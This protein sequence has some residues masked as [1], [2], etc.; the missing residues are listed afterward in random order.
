M[1][2]R[3]LLV[4]IGEKIERLRAGTSYAAV[5]RAAGCS[6]GN[7]RQLEAGKIASPRVELCLR[8]ARHFGVP[9][10][11]LADEAQDWPPPA[12]DDE[13]AAELVRGALVGAGLAGE[14][15]RDERELLSR[16]RSLS[17]RHRDRVLGL[18]IGLASSGG[19]EEAAEL[20][21]DVGEALGEADRQSGE[22]PRP[23]RAEGAAC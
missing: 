14:L 5:A 9:L 3:K 1:G 20:A 16:Y 7:L 18:V 4:R 8:I 22:A 21:A 17:Q 15:T 10:D 19:D 2:S 6:E 12:S 11:W 23:R 13:Q